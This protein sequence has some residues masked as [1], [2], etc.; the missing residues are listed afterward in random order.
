MQGAYHKH[1]ML[2]IEIDAKDI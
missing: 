1:V 2:P